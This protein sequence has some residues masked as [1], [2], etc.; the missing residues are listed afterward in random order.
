[1]KEF[2]Q[3]VL[4][5]NPKNERA[6]GLTD[7]DIVETWEQSLEV[8]TFEDEM[9]KKTTFNEVVEKMIRKA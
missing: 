4:E 9:N 6:K 7:G 2:L 5:D 8:G 1:M 3:A